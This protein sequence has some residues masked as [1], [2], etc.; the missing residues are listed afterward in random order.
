MELWRSSSGGT[1]RLPRV[2]PSSSSGII[3]IIATHLFRE[4]VC[5]EIAQGDL[6]ATIGAVD[7]DLDDNQ[8]VQ[9]HRDVGRHG[10]QLRVRLAAT[11]LSAGEERV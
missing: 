8:R 9:R 6:E 1:A 2:R 4:D 5:A 10:G 11:G 7:L 3:S